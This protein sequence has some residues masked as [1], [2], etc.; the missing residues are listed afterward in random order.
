MKYSRWTIA[1]LAVIGFLV[2]FLVLHDRRVD[3]E[4]RFYAGPNVITHAVFSPD[5]TLLVTA[6]RGSG[7][8]SSEPAIFLK[9]FDVATGK[10]L[11]TFRCHKQEVKALVVIS[12]PRKGASVNFSR[13]RRHRT[14]HDRPCYR[15][16]MSR[17]LFASA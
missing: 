12:K 15:S 9:V 14:A 11:R 8:T 5:N 13:G 7:E 10:R 3:E 4:G 6:Y 1:T 16:N 17:L 2:F